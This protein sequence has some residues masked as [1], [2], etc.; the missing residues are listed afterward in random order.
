MA[1]SRWQEAADAFAASMQVRATA[2]AALNLGISLKNLGRLVEARVRLQQFQEMAS[3]TLRR[4]QGAHAQELLL[5][6]TGYE[7]DGRRITIAVAADMKPVRSEFDRLTMRYTQVSVAMFVLL[8]IL[9]IGIVR[10]ALSPLRRVRADVSRLDRGEIVQLGDRV[11]AEVLPLVREVNRLLAYELLQLLD[12]TVR[13]ANDGHEALEALLGLQGVGRRRGHRDDTRAEACPERVDELQPRGIE[14]QHAL[15][16]LASLPELSG[17]VARRTIELRVGVRNG[18]L[19]LA[20]VAVGDAVGRLA[21]ARRE[22]RDEVVVGVGVH[23]CFSLLAP[24]RVRSRVIGASP[25][26]R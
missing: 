26:P 22:E 25:R 18:A 5:S 11:P 9:Q 21:G 6:A 23:R 13:V 19:R 17:D 24:T 16:A 2:S 4:E 12:L 7:R 3:E 14:Q 8:V 15:A 10:L 1:A 20:E